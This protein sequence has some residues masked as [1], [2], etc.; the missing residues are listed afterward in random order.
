[1]SKRFFEVFP[2]LKLDAKTK[3]I[4]EQTVVDKVS[5]T[6]KQDFI[7]VYISSKNLIDKADILKAETGIKKQ[8]F[9]NQDL[10]V[11]IYEKF[12]LSAQYTPKNLIDIYK[13]SIELELKDYDHMEY[14]LFRSA[15]FLYPEDGNIVIQLEDS[16][17]GQKKA[18]DL[19]RVLS[20]IINERCGLSASITPEF[21][22]VVKETEEPDYSAESAKMAKKLEAAEQRSEEKKKQKEEQ[23]AAKE[24]AAS[25]KKGAAEKTAGK[26]AGKE[27]GFSKGK[28]SGKRDFGGIRG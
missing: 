4:M 23:E 27:G 3:E 28:W 20:K 15:Q 17:V 2:T 1:M 9:G 6:R 22:E 26:P 19:V 8:F 14:S 11:K 25:A 18:P 13:D 10:T 24:A 12:S 16:V 7:R 5:T 21:I